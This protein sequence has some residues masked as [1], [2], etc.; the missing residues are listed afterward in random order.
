V[1]RAAVAVNASRVGN[2]WH[3]DRRLRLDE[4]MK[5]TREAMVQHSIAWS[6]PV[7][8]GLLEECLRVN[9]T[10]GASFLLRVRATQLRSSRV[11]GVGGAVSEGWFA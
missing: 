10:K 11:T 6:G 2:E 9:H 1:I 8:D 4:G 3:G 5:V 7:V